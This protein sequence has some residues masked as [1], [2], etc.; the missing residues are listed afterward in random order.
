MNNMKNNP[1]TL[2]IIYIKSPE[3]WVLIE[4]P[5]LYSLLIPFCVECAYR[6]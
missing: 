4:L 3:K 5:S 1:T 6:C 2:L